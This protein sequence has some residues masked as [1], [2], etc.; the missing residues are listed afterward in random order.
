MPPALLCFLCLKLTLLL[1]NKFIDKRKQKTLKRLASDTFINFQVK[2][3]VNYYFFFFFLKMDTFLVVW[4]ENHSIKC[5]V[6]LILEK[7]NLPIIFQYF[8]CCIALSSLISFS[9]RIS[10]SFF[11]TLS[12]AYPLFTLPLSI[13]LSPPFFTLYISHFL[14]VEN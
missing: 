14:S 3:L 4:F 5:F 7:K 10:L 11:D 2:V 1:I 6:F 9:R 12:F 8:P 13:C